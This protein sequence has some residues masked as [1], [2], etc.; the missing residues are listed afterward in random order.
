MLSILLLSY[1]GE[2]YEIIEHLIKEKHHVKYWVEEPD[3]QI[4]YK[5]EKVNRYQDHLETADLVVS[6]HPRFGR[7]C[8]ELRAGGKV[9]I[10]GGVQD[11]VTS[12]PVFQTSLVKLLG[13]IPAV[14]PKGPRILICGWFDGQRFVR[15]YVVQHYHR[16]LDGER[17][18]LV[19][20][21]GYVAK[22]EDFTMLEDVAML[23][24]QTGYRGFFGVET[25]F[26][27][28]LDYQLL[29][30]ITVPSGGL[31]AAISE[32]EV[33][34]LGH[35]LFSVASGRHLAHPSSLYYGMSVN[36]RYFTPPVLETQ[37]RAEKHIWRDGDPNSF[38]YVSARGEDIREA[39]RRIY[40]TIANNTTIDAIYRR[41]IGLDSIWDWKGGD[42]ASNI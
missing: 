34:P 26:D 38:G 39:R 15:H 31:I 14:N 20:G 2:G 1:K 25:V 22:V 16:F 35:L 33:I 30:T 13:I 40:R 21:M 37:E 18:P 12:S 19:Q 4:V 29:E 6:L 5:G 17:G 9:V 23:L 27:G 36:V 11:L 8:E 10:G 32:C 3:P 28:S 24:R 41:D 7:I 42:H